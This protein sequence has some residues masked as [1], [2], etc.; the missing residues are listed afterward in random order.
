MRKSFIFFIIFFVGL[1]FFFLNLRNSKE[2]EEITA[3]IASSN[4][5]E[6]KLL[7]NNNCG[8]C[9]SVAFEEHKIGP[10][11]HNIYE[12][13]SGTQIGYTNYGEILTKINLQWN[14]EEL[15]NY[16]RYGSEYIEG[17]KMAYK[18]IES[19]SDAAAIVA[20]LKNSE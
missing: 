10:S 15:F 16:V 19:D 18:G 2:K 6:G 8:H 17:T 9:H 3:I 5:A 11:L 20:Y 14:D 1:A 12:K 13:I 4:T 7:F